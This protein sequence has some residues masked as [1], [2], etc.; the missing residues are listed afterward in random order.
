MNQPTRQAQLTA[1]AFASEIRQ[2]SKLTAWSV[3]PFLILMMLALTACG[4]KLQGTT[5]LPFERLSITISDNTQFGADVRRAIRAVSPGTIIIPNEPLLKGEKQI[6]QAQ[7]Q[8]IS[9]DRNIREVS[10]NPQGRVEEYELTLTFTFRLVNARNE[11]ILPDTTLVSVRD[12]PYDDNVVQAKEGEIATLFEQM[13]R[14]MVD[15]LIRRI[16]SPDV[17]QTYERLERDAAQ[18]T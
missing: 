9:V 3:W 8:Q 2:R 16:T 4:F 13:Q 1:P 15:R 12:L 11:V 17:I 7:L 18:N 5:Q 14:G 10:L 6:Y